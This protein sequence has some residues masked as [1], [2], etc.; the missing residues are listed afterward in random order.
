M[1]KFNIDVELVGDNGNA[2]VILAKVIKAL[3][4]ANVSKSDIEDFQNEATSGDYDHL[5]AT[6]MK[7]VNVL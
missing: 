2:F 1:A 7:W 4:R 6:C 5:L 3:R